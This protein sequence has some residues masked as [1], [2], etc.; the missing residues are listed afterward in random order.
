MPLVP[1][2]LVS[3]G[4]H[5]RL[6]ASGVGLLVL[7]L[8]P[9]SLLALR[10]LLPA[11]YPLLAVVWWLLAVANAGL[12]RLLAA[13][14][15]RHHAPARAASCESWLPW[16]AQQLAAGADEAE[17]RAYLQRTLPGNARPRND[18]RVSGDVQ[19]DGAP[20]VSDGPTHID[21][22]LARARRKLR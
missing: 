5:P 21:E 2:Q 1:P 13:R 3:A 17:L 16:I 20:Q 14:W 9:A 19:L 4:F 22:M 18:G 7:L 12:G 6:L 8:C 11:G 10:P 15:W